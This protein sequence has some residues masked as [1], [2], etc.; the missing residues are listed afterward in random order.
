MFP[1]L[2]VK[3]LVFVFVIVACIWYSDKL[4]NW[5][6]LTFER[7]CEN[8]ANPSNKEL[9]N[10]R[11]FFTNRFG[12]WNTSKIW[13][14]DTTQKV[15]Y[16]QPSVLKGRTD[17]VTVT[18][19]LAPIVWE[20]TFDPQVIDNIFKNLK[21]TVAT[22][23]FAVGKYVKF[24]Q[25]FFDTAE[26]HFMVDFNVHYYVF[27]DR[28]ADM[29]L[30]NLKPGRR[31]TVIPVP[32]LDRWQEISARR[33]A[34]IR[35]AIVQNISKEADYV[36]CLDV[37]SKFHARFGAEA[38]GDLVAVIHPG[39]Y[40]KTHRDQFPY[41]RRP[42]STAYIP[43]GQGDFYYGGA[44][45]GGLVGNVLN[46]STECDVRFQEDAKNK[47]EAAWQEES[48]L[49]R[50]LFLNKPTKVLSSEYL[51]Q[52]FKARTK[53]VKVLRFSGVIKNY[54]EVRPNL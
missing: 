1:F 43:L 9:Q 28:P 35:D 50:Y 41:E 18:P 13:A 32:T 6:S 25:D 24:L 53:E 11:I 52:D 40:E 10:P 34:Y 16:K 31:L 4:F 30:T 36:F 22:T 8:A 29:P 48:H 42:D 51:W 26:K 12:R 21:L 5:T 39:Y 19:W 27:T 46:L 44:L 54:G 14:M 38:L 23:V 49:N 3:P 37:D 2:K 47:I 7:Y 33:M 15:S 20:G 45:F 17:I